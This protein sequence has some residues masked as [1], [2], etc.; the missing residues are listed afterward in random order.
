MRISVWVFC[1][2]LSGLA[3]ADKTL[4]QAVNL[5]EQGELDAAE[6]QLKGMQSTEPGRAD[7][8]TWYVNA[9]G[10]AGGSPEKAR[11]QA[12]EIAKRNTF[13]GQIGL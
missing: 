6:S 13:R 5:Y 11:E 1:A 9:P 7:L 4:Q 3:V 8:V 2:L 12:M 10:I